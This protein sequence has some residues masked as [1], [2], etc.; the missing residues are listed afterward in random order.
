MVFF[1]SFYIEEY[2]N[3]LYIYLVLEYKLPTNYLPFDYRLLINN[4]VT[5]KEDIK[6]DDF[7]KAA[8]Y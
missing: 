8:M 3:S 2:V 7:T 1:Y 6:V 4:T 5:C